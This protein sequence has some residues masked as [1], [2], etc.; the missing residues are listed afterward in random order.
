MKNE[1]QVDQSSTLNFICILSMIVIL[2]FMIVPK[3]Y[4][5]VPSSQL[6]RVVSSPPIERTQEKPTY[7][8]LEMAVRDLNTWLDQADK[9]CVEGDIERSKEGY[10]MVNAILNQ[11]GRA[12][13]TN[14]ET[15]L[16]LRASESTKNK[17]IELEECM[18]A[19]RFK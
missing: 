11:I 10:K 17:V 2:L 18:K 4:T 14:G 5:E 13:K 19:R 8:A 12:N 7:D 6:S 16:S 9:A 15:W 3:F 1:S